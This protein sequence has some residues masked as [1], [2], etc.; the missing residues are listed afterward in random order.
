MSKQTLKQAKAEEVAAYLGVDLA[1][2]VFQVCGTDAQGRVLFNK[3]FNRNQLKKFMLHYPASTV[4]VEACSG[5]HYWARTF[6]GLGH[7][8]KIMA[9]QF[10]KPYVRGNKN[11]RND[12]RAIAEALRQP[13]MKFVSVKTVE[14]QDI[15]ML[16][17]HRSLL[18]KKRTALSNELRG[19]LSEYGVVIPQGIRY[20][21]SQLPDILADADNG[22]TF[23]G[24]DIFADLYDSLL[25]YD[26][27]IAHYEKMINAHAQQD[28]R[29][30]RL[31]AI[32]G[33]GPITASAVVASVGNATAFNHCRE[34][35]SWLGVVPRHRASGGKCRMLGVSKRGD[36]Y[37]RTLL[38]HGARSVINQAHKK[39]DA[40]SRWIMRKVE[41]P[42]GRNKTAVA[43]ASKNARVIW[44][45]LSKDG[46][47]RPAQ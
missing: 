24:R 2:N 34:F 25:M 23:K 13:D 14:Q 7:D 35:A 3:R 36:R 32:E 46:V 4:G 45:L 38:I 9:A 10:V 43:L 6:M 27:R 40:R 47:Y 41:Q 42:G 37:L 1:K 30:V 20:V 17:R 12:A 11:D 16:H 29:C 21:R 39:E 18:V 19:M 22:L 44:A 8:V 28:E 15:L 33:V 31:M 5:A 26:K